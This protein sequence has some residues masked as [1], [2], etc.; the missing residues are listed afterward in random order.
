VGGG[1]AV[2]VAVAIAVGGTGVARVDAHRAVE[3]GDLGVHGELIIDEDGIL[4]PQVVGGVDQAA[5][6]DAVGVIVLVG[7]LDLVS[8]EEAAGNV[9]DGD[10]IIVGVAP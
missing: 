8:G 9:A 7:D 2:A 1:F 10:G 3:V 6:E 5:K 4:D